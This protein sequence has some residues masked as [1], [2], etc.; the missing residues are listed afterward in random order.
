MD[1]DGTIVGMAGFGVSV[2]CSVWL[3]WLYERE[4]YY[5]S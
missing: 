3:L 5:R 2:P 1:L 4:R